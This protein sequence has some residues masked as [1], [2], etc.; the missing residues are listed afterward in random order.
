MW[1]VPVF[2]ECNEGAPQLQRLDSKTTNFRWCHVH[3][4]FCLDNLDWRAGGK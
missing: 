4:A 1:D 2:M 3:L